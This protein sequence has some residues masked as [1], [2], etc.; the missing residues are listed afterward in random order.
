MYVGGQK[1]CFFDR[2][3]YARV[4][5]GAFGTP[6]KISKNMDSFFWGQWGRIFL[7]FFGVS[8]NL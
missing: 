5:K 4:P 2:V 3:Q 8:Y 7:D 1:L 6:N